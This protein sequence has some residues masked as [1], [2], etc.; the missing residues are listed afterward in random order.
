MNNFKF[1]GRGPDYSKY[2]KP[3]EGLSFVGVGP[4]LFSPYTFTPTRKLIY[5]KIITNEY[6]GGDIIGENHEL[7]GEGNWTQS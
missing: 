4:L 6:Y 2:D 7:W 1:L 3:D 5:H